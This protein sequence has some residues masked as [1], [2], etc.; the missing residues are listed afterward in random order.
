MVVQ[1]V[2]EGV[3]GTGYVGTIQI[4]FLLIICKS[5]SKLNSL[6]RGHGY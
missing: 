2:I 5:N 6:R 1:I 4:E 3:R